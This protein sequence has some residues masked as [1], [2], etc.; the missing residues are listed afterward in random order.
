MNSNLWQIFGPMFDHNQK[1]QGLPTET[2]MSLL[3][4]QVRKRIYSILE[5]KA[6]KL[7]SNNSL[8]G[9]FKSTNN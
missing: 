7:V 6:C 1:L 8:I 3:L 9:N 2:Q 4:F 5:Y